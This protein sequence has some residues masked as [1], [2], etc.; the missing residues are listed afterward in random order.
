MKQSRKVLH[1]LVQL[2]LDPSVTLV[3]KRFLV[4]LAIILV[5]ASLPIAGSIGL[6]R[7]S[8]TL[9]GVNVVMCVVWALVR[10]ERPNGV[11]LTHWDEALVMT[12]LWAAAHLI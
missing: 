12:G 6:R 5:F 3:S 7:L 10:R 2:P 8:I 1:G 9:M 4:R 11:G